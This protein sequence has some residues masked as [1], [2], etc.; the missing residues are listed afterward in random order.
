MTLE[1]LTAKTG[2]LSFSLFFLFPRPSFRSEMR[3]SAST[4]TTNKTCIAWHW[5]VQLWFGSILSC[6]ADFTTALTALAFY[7]F[8]EMDNA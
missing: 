4:S 5:V 8:M 2:F 1:T 3:A 7:S 6:K